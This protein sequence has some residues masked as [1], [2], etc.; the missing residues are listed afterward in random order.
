MNVLF[1]HN[2]FPAQ[3]KH[4][5]RAL[6]K[7]ADVKMA[8]IGARTSSGYDGVNL[9]KY[10]LEDANVSATHPFGRRFDLECRR[11][12]QVLYAATTL[13][14][15]GF[16]PDLVMAHPGWGETLPLRTLFPKARIL[17]Y[18]EFYYGREDRDV[19]FDHEFPETGLDGLVGLH[20]KNASTVLA[21]V[22][23]D[24]GVSPTRWQRSTYPEVLR[25]TIKVIH[26]GIDV[27][28]MKPSSE[29][30]FFLSTGR[31]LKRSDEVVT[32]VARN[33]EP[34]RGYHIFMRA[35]PRI[36]A[37]RPNAEILVIGGDGTSYGALP[38]EGKTWR[39]I[40]FDEVAYKI[41][42]ARVHFTGRLSHEK[43]LRAL[44]ISSAHVYLTYPFVLSWSLMEALST[45]CVVIG[46]DTAP[47][48][49]VVDNN[50]GIL[51]SFFDFDQLAERVID[52]LAHP[53]RFDAMRARA[54]QTIIEH[55]DLTRICLPKMMSLINEI[56]A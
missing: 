4:I 47:V 34:V 53:R 1:V 29:A 54:R 27:D 35:L 24:C 20:L 7:Q 22:E 10:G 44:Q 52:A 15:A 5:V 13:R 45:G 30:T 23:S 26:E 12:E 43:F 41:D 19:G 33:L 11:A 49:E 38:P 50:N 16:V 3:Y 2:N 25:Q 56:T 28:M 46:S 8:A 14:S 18:C 42:L 39:S 48:R 9:L 51:V 17:T 37:E 36:L 32:F 40:F 21:L 55:Y 31:E 6:S